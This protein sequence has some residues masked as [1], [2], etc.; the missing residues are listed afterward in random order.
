M[1]R[2]RVGG[3]VRQF[4]FPDFRDPLGSAHK[5]WVRATLPSFLEYLHHSRRSMKHFS[6]LVRPPDGGTVDLWLS[7]VQREGEHISGK[8][9]SAPRNPSLLGQEYLAP[10]DNI[11]DWL[12]VHNLRLVGGVSFRSRVVKTFEYFECLR[13]GLAT[14]PDP[15]TEDWEYTDK[16]ESF[17]LPLDEERRRGQVFELFDAIG[18]HEQEKI[19]EY[20]SDKS[21]IDT[22]CD[23][24][25]RIT[26][27]VG[28][29]SLTPLLYAIECENETAAVFCIK[30]GAQLDAHDRNG[31]NA[32][33][34][35]MVYF[36]AVVSLLNEKGASLKART[37]SGETALTLAIS[38]KSYESM[39]ILIAAGADVNDYHELILPNNTLRVARSPVLESLD[40]QAAKILN[41]A[42]ANFEVKNFKGETALHIAAFNNE[43]DLADFLIAKG[44]NPTACTNEGKTPAML[45]QEFPEDRKAA[46]LFAKKCEQYVGK[47]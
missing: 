20:L 26:I 8:V 21:L 23:V 4:P 17:C 9:T 46:T 19:E 3:I 27:S 16:L 41:E 47:K 40:L 18:N 28:R 38:S 12:Y 11:V 5:R 44:C 31:M 7:D 29:D 39:K 13:S 45:A 22:R 43:F 34:N 15:C 36:P 25:V 35:V 6:V 32:L 33:Q 2:T 10:L 30:S 1:S 37:Y 14:P 24:A 42:G